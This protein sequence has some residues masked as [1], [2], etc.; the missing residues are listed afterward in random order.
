[1][2]KESIR[3]HFRNIKRYFR[4]NTASRVAVAGL[5]VLA[6][7]LLASGVFLIARSGLELTQEGTD[8]FVTEA[9][10]LYIYQ[11]FLLVT[12]FLIFASTV[13]F[14]LF[15]FFRGEDDTWIISSPAYGALPWVKF[16]RALVDSSWPVV[17][18]AV[19][20]LLAV[21]SV[22]GLS[23]LF[24]STAFLGIILF[25]FICAGAAMVS[26]FAISNLMRLFGSNNFATLSVAM[27]L[28][29]I[30]LGA[31][32]WSRTVSVDL[33]MIFQIE[34]VSQPT[35]FSLQDNFNPF[36]SHF[37]AMAIH[38][39][40]RGDFADAV[41]EVS[42]TALILLSLTILFGLLKKGFLRLWQG[43]Q[44]G[45]FQAKTEAEKREKP[46]S[47][48]IL[49]NSPEDVIFKKEL[50]T[51]V[52]SPR[53]SFWFI[54][55]MMLLFIQV[56]A[57]NLLGRYVEL[58]N[59]GDMAVTGPTPFLQIGMIL[60]LISSFVLRFVFPSF[61]QE[62][63][64]SW[65]IG[66]APIDLKTVFRAK[67]RFYVILL[68]LV[69]LLALSIYL[70]AFSLSTILMAGLV[71]TALV[72]V[73]TLTMIGLSLGTAFPNFTT[74]DPHKLSTSVPG[75]AFTLMAVAYSMI[76]SYLLYSSFILTNYLP[77]I[78]FL[79]LSAVIYKIFKILALK[80][81][82]KVEFI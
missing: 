39:L 65:I 70:L 20:L 55:L 14:S 38:H 21:H 53:D 2:I 1:M 56:G 35:L 11:I 47:L 13:I 51:G 45:S 8:P 24:F 7:A 46:F 72:G 3:Y 66:S 64:T 49:P 6:I 62:G 67:S 44:E 28:I 27:A 30:S 48:K 5:M 15:S 80:S 73:V 26:I 32:I 34:E 58:G 42:V 61:S 12:G 82:D 60:F 36:P 79:I 68:S 69:G 43:F 37:P 33:E 71:V 59:G 41:Q 19:P 22:F 54:F 18:I 77:F 78:A 50:L 29:T 10:P 25:S 63:E 23:P 81:L 16:I 40:Q 4:E 17:V 76:G 75:I 74:N 57:I 9:V 52:R 31:A